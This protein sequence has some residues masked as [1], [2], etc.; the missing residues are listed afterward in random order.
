MAY[1]HKGIFCQIQ[2]NNEDAIFYFNK[3]I[4]LNSKFTIAY[5][6]K[7]ILL[8]ILMKDEEEM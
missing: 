3:A 2:K 4:E 1:L 8:K 6:V 5:V 7:G